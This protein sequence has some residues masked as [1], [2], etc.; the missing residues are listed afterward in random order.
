MQ[1]GRELH[2]DD[3]MKRILGGEQQS[4]PF[5]RPQINECVFFE[6]QLEPMKDLPKY[7]RGYPMVPGVE[8]VLS[9]SGG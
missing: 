9:T 6:V 5:A 8:Q 2:A 4:A 3:R 7:G 1:L